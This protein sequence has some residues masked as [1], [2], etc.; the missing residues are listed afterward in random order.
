M[1]HSEGWQM[2]AAFTWKFRWKCQPESFGCVQCLLSM[3][4]GH[5]GTGGLSSKRV[6]WSSKV[7]RF[8]FRSYRA[9]LWPHSIDLCR[10]WAVPNPL[11]RGLHQG[12][13]NRQ[14]DS[15]RSIATDIM[16]LFSLVE[17]WDIW[18]QVIVPY[19]CLYSC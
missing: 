5:L 17:L 13:N 14:C 2:V 6:C 9:S 10:F 7:L 12:M 3:K 15:L 8:S 1:A 18:L 4:T 11:W 16:C 19:H